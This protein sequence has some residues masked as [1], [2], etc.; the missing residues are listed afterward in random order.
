MDAFMAFKEW[1]TAADFLTQLL[2]IVGLVAVTVGIF[3][4]IYYIIKGVFWVLYQIL[5]LFIELI[6][7]IFGIGKTFIPKTQPAPATTQ[8]TANQQLIHQTI[9]QPNPNTTS[10]PTVQVTYVAA[11]PTQMAQPVQPTQT[12]SPSIQK[13]HCPNCGQQFTAQMIQL[14]AKD[15]K[16]FCEYCGNVVEMVR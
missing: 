4:L 8:P 6:K 12:M 3:A 1:F 2:V 15:G 9:I 13:L 5:K 14:I 10:Q 11:Q 16:T 7:A